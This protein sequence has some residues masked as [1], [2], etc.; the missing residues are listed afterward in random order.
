[1]FGKA[2][3]LEALIQNKDQLD[4]AVAAYQKLNEK[5]PKGTYQAVADR[6]IEQLQK[7]DA[8]AFYDALAQYTPRPKVE[9][10]RQ[11]GSP[12]PS[13]RIRR[14]SRWCR[15]RPSG[16]RKSTGSARTSGTVFDANRAGETDYA[17]TG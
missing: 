3:A 14:M 6:Q 9:S 15:T 13:W 17:E 5:F 16:R 7:K 12:A 11:P 1:M 10:P 4:E 8:M 2:R